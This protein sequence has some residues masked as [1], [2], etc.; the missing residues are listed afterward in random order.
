[1][2]PSALVTKYPPATYIE[3]IGARPDVNYETYTLDKLRTG[4]VDYVN[5]FT[6]TVVN[7][8]SR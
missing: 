8:I 7:L 1:V 5:A 6:Q 3:T 2:R 4:G